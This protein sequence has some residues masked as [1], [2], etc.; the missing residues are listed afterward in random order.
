MDSVSDEIESWL[1][2]LEM[3]EWAVVRDE[4]GDWIVCLPG[5][6][7]GGRGPTLRSAAER[8]V[9]EVRV[10]ISHRHREAVMTGGPIPYGGS[11]IWYLPDEVIEQIVAGHDQTPTDRE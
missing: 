6:H 10:L 7:V 1:A 8:A 2:D 4:A 9:D 5:W 11:A 3:P